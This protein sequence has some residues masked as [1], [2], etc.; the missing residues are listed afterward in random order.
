MA[1][2]TADAM[3]KHRDIDAAQKS[4]HTQADVM[5]EPDDDQEWEE[6][7]LQAPVTMRR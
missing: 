1:Y 4:T 5:P 2:E 3:L 7:P 6:P